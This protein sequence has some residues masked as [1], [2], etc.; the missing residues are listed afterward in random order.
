MPRMN[1]TVMRLVDVPQ[2]FEARLTVSGDGSPLDARIVCFLVPPDVEIP[3][4]PD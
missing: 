2:V 4:A 1:T 3:G